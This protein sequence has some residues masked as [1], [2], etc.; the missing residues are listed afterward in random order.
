MVESALVGAVHRPA[1]SREQAGDASRPLRR[2]GRVVAHLVQTRVEAAEVVH[3]LV[4]WR[5]EHDRLAG[6]GVRRQRQD[7]LR[8]AEP[9]IDRRTES[10]EVGAGLPGLQRDHRR[11][12]GDEQGWKRRV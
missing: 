11:A 8:P 1:P 3:R 7:R 9:G 5:G 12:V 6:Q 4:A 2:A 10:P